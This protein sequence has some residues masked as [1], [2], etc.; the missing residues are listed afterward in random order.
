MRVIEA[1]IGQSSNPFSVGQKSGVANSSTANSKSHSIKSHSIKRLANSLSP[2]LWEGRKI[3][4]RIRRGGHKHFAF[5]FG[6]SRLPSPTYAIINDGE[7]DPPRGR[8]TAQ[9]SF[10]A[11]Q[12]NRAAN[13]TS[14][15]PIQTSRA[16]IQTNRA[17]VQTRPSHRAGRWLTLCAI[18][19]L[20]CFFVT[21]CCANEFQLSLNNGSVITV[22]VDQ[23]TIDWTSVMENGDMTKK[24]IPF[25]DV[26][27]LLL[28]KAPASKQVA[29]IQRFLSMLDGKDFL[30]R[31]KAEEQLSDPNI[32]G[33]FKSL[34]KL[35]AKSGSPESRYRINR[36]LERLNGQEEL[37]LS[38]FDQLTLKDGTVLEGDAGDLNIQ[39][40]FRGNKS[41]FKRDAIR[42]ISTPV[43]L[44]KLLAAEEEIQVRMYHS[45]EEVDEK[46]EATPHFYRDDQVMVDF[47]NAPKGAELKRQTSVNDTFIPFGLR[48][49]TAQV[50]YIGISG[51]PFKFSPLPVSGNSICVFE[52]VGTY[53]KRFKGITEIRFCLPNQASVPAGVREVGLFI[54]RVNHSRD[55]ILEAYNA[56]GELLAAVESTDKP[57][58]FAGVKSNEPIAKLRILSNPYL[59]RVDR[60][61]DEDY[62][63]DSICFSP[64]VAVP[65]P[66]DS[67]PGVIR[68]KNGD[69]I[70]A[71]Q[72]S[73]EETKGQ[74]ASPALNSKLFDTIK[75]DNNSVSIQ[76]SQTNRMTFRLDELQTI[77]FANELNGTLGK[78]K[79]LKIGAANQSPNTWMAILKDRSTISVQ[80][81]L[82]MTSTSFNLSFKAED[83][84]GLKVSRN[85][86]RYPE[87]S[88]FRMGNRVLVFPTCRIASNNL[89][90]SEIGYDWKASDE[91]IEQPVQIDQDED[92]QD[93]TPNFTSVNYDKNSPEIIPTLWLAPPKSQMPGTG[94]LRLT[95]GQQLTLGGANGFKIAGFEDGAV[96]VSIAGEKTPIPIKKVLS[97][98]FPKQR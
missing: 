52:T 56:D 45:H 54:A 88:D 30:D 79:K 84:L 85:P 75:I 15:A 41:S 90:L 10:G 37:A 61:I 1:T 27:Q 48:L 63:V 71:V 67:K 53:A 87:A 62:G 60:A 69:L 82:K 33:R 86:T 78:N 43:D 58:V 4:L 46:G 97:I 32:G 38:E 65:S 64:P 93:P 49:D 28:S 34:I 14:S 3:R 35:R 50:G 70:K 24:S 55:F 9:T 59:F 74:S 47:N 77:R 76:V 11:I 17:T 98:D 36:I 95:D 12:T 66:A 42:L 5:C 81:G 2:S 80:P 8:V 25:S 96:I 94:K 16:A 40:D 26:K 20:S 89:S 44:P 19:L 39:C 83:I 73:E 6:N 29:R 51:Y 31:E 13:Q 23:Q 22:E 57:C 7:I 68:L 21:T 92:E 91:K 18:T 72:L